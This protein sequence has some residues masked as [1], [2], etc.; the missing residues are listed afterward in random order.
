[1]TC[2]TMGLCTPCRYDI[3]GFK[4]QTAERLQFAFD[5][6]AYAQMC[7]ALPQHIDMQ[8]Q[9]CKVV[10]EGSEEVVTRKV[11]EESW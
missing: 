1:M 2:T 6:C 9:G 3:N 4:G 10:L 8:Q 5:A 11:W 7:I